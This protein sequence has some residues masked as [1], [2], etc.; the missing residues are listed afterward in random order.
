MQDLQPELLL[1]AISEELPCGKD[2]GYEPEFLELEVKGSGKPE[3]QFGAVVIAAEDPDWRAVHELSIK[4]AHQTRDLRLAIWL[5]RSSARVQGLSGVAAGLHLLRGL[6]E[7]HWERVHPLLDTTENND[8][9]ER[10]SAFAILLDRVAG[11]ADLRSAM[12]G[13]KSIGMSF[14]DIELAWGADAPRVDEIVGTRESTVASLSRVFRGAPETAAQMTSVHD[15]VC[16]IDASLR[17][18]L[19]SVVAPDMRHLKKLLKCVADAAAQATQHLAGIAGH[20]VGAALAAAGSTSS[21]LSSRADIVSV[22]NKLCEWLEANEPGH[23]APLLLR[24]ASRLLTMSFV[25]IVRDLVPD[26]ITK[27][28]GL[29]GV[30]F[31]KS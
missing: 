25:E 23:P 3:Q 28:E 31:E 4:L 26:S 30:R 2:M 18:H 19:G 7:R 29:A 20:V 1:S 22:I 12:V 8:P 16:A 5:I 21:I 27:L 13:D 11:M 6:V 10:L 17:G 14:R 24:R 9:T 15:D